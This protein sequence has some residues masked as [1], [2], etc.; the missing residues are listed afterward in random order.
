MENQDEH[1]FGLLQIED[2]NGQESVK[3]RYPQ[4]GT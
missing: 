4:D 1:S 2:Q 3:P